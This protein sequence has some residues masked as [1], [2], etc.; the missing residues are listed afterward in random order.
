MKYDTRQNKDQAEKHKHTKF[1]KGLYSKRNENAKRM[2]WPSFW[3]LWLCDRHE[4][5][6]HSFLLCFSLWENAFLNPSTLFGGC[7]LMNI[8]TINRLVKRGPVCG[9]ALFIMASLAC[10]QSSKTV[11]PAAASTGELR[12]YEIKL[13]DLAPPEVMTGP[14]N[15]SKVI[16]RP[17][18]AE[19]TVPPGFQISVY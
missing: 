1:W 11:A 3:R 16:P 5:C 15:V 19:L 2:K 12:H 7:D 17:E 9:V 6:A 18:G 13:A 14:R 8:A 10:A 4:S